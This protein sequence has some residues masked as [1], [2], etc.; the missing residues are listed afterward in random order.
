VSTDISVMQITL[1]AGLYPPEMDSRARLTPSRSV[2]KRSR[3]AVGRAFDGWS[4]EQ[5]F[6][7]IA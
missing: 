5:E 3:A 1:L 4:H 7:G 2:R 6:Q